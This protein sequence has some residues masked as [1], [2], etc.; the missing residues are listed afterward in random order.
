[1]YLD[2]AQARALLAAAASRSPDGSALVALSVTTAVI[3]RIRERGAGG[4]GGAGGGLMG[5]WK[6]GCPPDPTEVRPPPLLLG[7]VLGCLQGAAVCSPPLPAALHVC[8]PAA[9]C[10]LIAGLHRA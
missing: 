4:A 3:D 7:R 6:F 9:L 10:A 1:M 5:T 2:E 8:A